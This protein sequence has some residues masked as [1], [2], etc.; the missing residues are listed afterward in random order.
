MSKLLWRQAALYLLLTTI[1]TACGAPGFNIAPP[2]PDG[3]NP[4]TAP[5]KP[6]TRPVSRLMTFA[7]APSFHLGT[8]EFAAGRTYAVG[9]ESGR[10]YL[11]A[12]DHAQRKIVWQ[13][14]LADYRFS[15]ITDDER[16]LLYRL[17][18][19]TLGELSRDGQLLREL[20]LSHHEFLNPVSVS[21]IDD[22]Y[23]IL[24][25]AGDIYR[26]SL[27]GK[28]TFIMNTGKYTPANS[29]SQFQFLPD[30]RWYAVNCEDSGPPHA[31]SCALGDFDG[32]IWENEA[33]CPSVSAMRYRNGQ[34]YGWVTRS[35]QEFGEI[36][37]YETIYMVDE[38]GEP[39][40]AYRSQSYSVDGTRLLPLKWEVDYEGNLYVIDLTA[41]ERRDTRGRYLVS[42]SPDGTQRWKRELILPEI[43]GRILLTSAGEVILQVAEFAN[44]ST[45]HNVHYRAF[46]AE[47]GNQ[48]WRIGR[49]TY[50]TA[51]AIDPQGRLFGIFNDTRTTFLGSLLTNVWYERNVTD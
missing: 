27:D 32:V 17:N 30:K 9:T 50:G 5:S 3:P 31:Y 18:P 43:T 19:L 7:P 8:M 36:R 25:A 23:V 6:T 13:Y 15:T 35:I 2:S 46:S 1:I 49:Y 41:L 11:Y 20:D 4:P 14:Y 24:T 37:N 10:T 28:P 39:R 42:V 33:H 34:I 29:C 44:E 12:M 51:Y 26:L 16:I 22:T 38:S 45:L 48:L 47:T 21:F 40:E